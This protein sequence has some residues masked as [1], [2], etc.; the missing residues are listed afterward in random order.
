[1]VFAAQKLRMMKKLNAPTVIIVNDR[2]D[3]SG[4]IFGTFSMADV[5]NLVPADTNAELTRLLK[6]DTRKVIITKIF[7]FAKI[8][9]AINFRDNIIVMVDEAHRTQEG[10]LG[11]RMR[12]A[13]PNAFFFG[14]TGTPINKLDKNTFATFGAVEDRTGYMSRYSFADSVADNGNPSVA[15]RV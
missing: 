14:L 3:L 7:E 9:E 15:Q 5:P 13:L 12:M 10:D 4:Q 1:M 8:T 11:A 2:I 6:A